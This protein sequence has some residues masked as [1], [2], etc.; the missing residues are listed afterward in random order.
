[1]IAE[2]EPFELTCASAKVPQVVFAVT[3]PARRL[4]MSKYIVALLAVSV[5]ILALACGPAEAP[6]PPDAPAAP[7][8]APEAPKAPEAAPPAPPAP[9]APGK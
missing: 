7:S 5:S 4:F 9:P 8:G 1:L 6:K 3:K 2:D